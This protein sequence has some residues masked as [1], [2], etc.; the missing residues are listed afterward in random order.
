MTDPARRAPTYEDILALPANQVGQILAGGLHVHP[1]PAPRHAVATSNLGED[2][3][4]RFKRGRGG[5]G[6][7]VI[8]DEPEIHLAADIVVPDL[9]GWKLDLGVL[10]QR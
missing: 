2:L 9:A 5:P 3:G 10:W 4:P 6:G 8:L 1:R 7:W